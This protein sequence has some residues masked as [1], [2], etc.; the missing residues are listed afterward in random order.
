MAD[1][2]L[3][4]STIVSDIAM[5]QPKGYL[6]NTGKPVTRTPDAVRAGACAIIFNDLEEVLLE[7]RSDNGFWGLPGGVVEIG[8]S[9]EQAVIREVME[10]TGLEVVVTRLV[11]VYSDP[12]HHT[13]QGYP[14]GRL[15]HN[16]TVA[17][18]CERR[19]GE[20]RIS[21]ES[22]D[23]R[24]FGVDA[25]PDDILRS[26]IVRIRDAISRSPTSFIR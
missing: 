17:F 24:Y 10:E 26:N 18:E 9:V 11:G 20:L 6:D 5:F 21:E 2:L 13:I 4:S 25:L 14:D 1:S 12:K 23:L 16:V 7:R 3:A 15:F 19:G 22:F 8:E